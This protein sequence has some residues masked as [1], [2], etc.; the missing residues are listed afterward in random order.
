MKYDTRRVSSYLSLRKEVKAKQ[1]CLNIQNDPEKCLPWSILASLHPVQ[2]RNNHFRVSK[3]QEYERELNM[4]RIKYSVD[5]KDIE[6]LS[7]KTT[8]VL[9]SMSTKIKKVFPYYYRDHCKI[10][11]KFIIYHCWQNISLCIGERLEQTGIETM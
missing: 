10:S 8:L 5:I 2:H 3:Y 11:C 1:G 4:S 7:I 9:M 6:N